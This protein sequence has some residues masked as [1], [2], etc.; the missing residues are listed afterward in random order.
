MKK[1]LITA[2]LIIIIVGGFVTWQ[3]YMNA[4][5]RPSGPSGPAVC[6]QEAKLCPDGSYVGRT[7]PNCEF[8]A[9][10]VATQTQIPADWKTFTDTAQGIS[11][12]YPENLGTKYINTNQWPP[13]ITV[14]GMAFSCN[15]SQASIPE[16]STSLKTINGRSYCVNAKMEGAAGSNYVTYRY[17][18]EV[19]SNS[20]ELDF[21]L[22]YPQCANYPDPQMTECNNEETTF[23][24]NGL[25]DQIAQSVKM[26]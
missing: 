1:T 24:L 15:T 10:P 26:N 13:V 17:F 8:Q 19:N 23:D 22:Q 4:R 9:C 5:S 20:L 11:F 16:N 21:I 12:R 2:I 7:G 18:T 6:T 14:R 3:I 25:V